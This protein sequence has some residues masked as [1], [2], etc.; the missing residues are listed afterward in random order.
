MYLA[1]LKLI[2]LAEESTF[3]LLRPISTSGRLKL[4]NLAEE[5]TA[6]MDAL[7]QNGYNRLNLINLAEESTGSSLPVR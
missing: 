6:K 7:I 5:S 1:R 3:T 4:I 2:N